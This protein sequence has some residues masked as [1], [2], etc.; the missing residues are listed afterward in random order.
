[1][2]LKRTTTDELTP[3]V[4]LKEL[5]ETTLKG[6]ETLAVPDT[7]PPPVF[8]SVKLRSA[9]PPTPTA[10]KLTVPEGMTARAG[11]A[12]PVPVTVRLAEPPLEVKETLPL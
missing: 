9:E 7:V 2:G 1:V 10:P 6:L 4:R 12:S 8:V 5:P 3:A 11:A